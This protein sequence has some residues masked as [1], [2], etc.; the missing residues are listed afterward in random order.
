MSKFHKTT[1]SRQQNF[2]AISS[3]HGRRNP[4][5]QQPANDWSNQN[6]IEHSLEKKIDIESSLLFN[7]KN[8]TRPTVKPAENTVRKPSNKSEGKFYDTSVGFTHCRDRPQS[9][10]ESRIKGSIEC[11]AKTNASL[12]ERPLTSKGVRT[13]HVRERQVSE[14]DE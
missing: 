4:L 10:Q 6:K 5:N 9:K 8:H 7:Q 3:S 13:N 12:P 11:K 14:K 2:N 1:Y